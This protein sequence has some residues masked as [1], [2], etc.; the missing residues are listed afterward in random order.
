MKT[1]P[2]LK[3]LAAGLASVIFPSCVKYHNLPTD[4]SG[5]VATIR[6]TSAQRNVF[7]GES[8]TVTKVDGKMIAGRGAVATPVGGGPVLAVQEPQVQ[9]LPQ[10]VT[11]TLTGSTIYAADGPA[12]IDG[13]IGGSRHVTGDISFTPKPGGEYRVK[14]LLNRGTEAVWLVEEK[15]GKMVG[16]KVTKSR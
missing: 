3:L 5:P 16:Q 9:V 15:T 13:L 14:G 11:L 10:P 7:K 4:Y 12:M 2:C 8:F 1:A 6:G